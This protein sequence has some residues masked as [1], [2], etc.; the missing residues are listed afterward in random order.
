MLFVFKISVI[1]SSGYTVRHKNNY[2]EHLENYDVF[3]GV[4]KLIWGGNYNEA[5]TLSKI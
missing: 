3:I 5:E 2:N 4:L 1:S